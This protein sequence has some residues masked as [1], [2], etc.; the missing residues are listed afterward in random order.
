M[1]GEI[2]A[3]SDATGKGYNNW[4]D[5]VRAEANGLVAVAILRRGKNTWPWVVGPFEDK[6]AAQR[7]A[8]RLRAKLKREQKQGHE[9][10][11]FNV[12]V[13]PSWKDDR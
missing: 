13:R 5:L 1:T 8:N 10:T 2:P 4:D 7:A 12:F 9:H 6:P 3:Y 11:A